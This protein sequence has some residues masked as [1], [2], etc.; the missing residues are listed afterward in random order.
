MVGFHWLKEKTVFSPFD[1]VWFGLLVF[2]EYFFPA[3]S[4]EY[5]AKIRHNSLLSIALAYGI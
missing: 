1:V 5:E 2:S 3:V 4:I